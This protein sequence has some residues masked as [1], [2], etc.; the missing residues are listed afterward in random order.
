M[1]LLYFCR[2]EQTFT[3]WLKSTLLVVLFPPSIARNVMAKATA[4]KS[5]PAT[6]KAAPAAKKPAAKAAAKPAAK[7]AAKAA[8]KPAAKTKKK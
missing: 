7:P 1:L 4:P 2:P 8:A 3:L 5:K 6:K